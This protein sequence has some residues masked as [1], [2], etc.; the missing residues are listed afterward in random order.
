V[1]TLFAAAFAALLLAAPAAWAQNAAGANASKHGI[2]VVD[3]SYIFK[4]H[5]KFRATMDGMQ[6]EMKQIETQLEGDRKAIMGSEEQLR[7]L[8]PGAPEYST[9]DDQITQQKAQF[10]LKMT[11][12]RKDFLE[13]EAK[14]YYDTFQEVDQAIAYY[15]KNRQIGLVLRF[16]GEAPDP[17]VREDILRAINK[18]VVYQDQIDITPDVLAM[19]NARAGQQ[20]AQPAGGAAAPAS[21]ARPGSTVRQ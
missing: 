19:L 10:Q 11:R 15:A 1:R 13:R 20:A 8:K 5:A 6:G 17:N 12:L 4:N 7:A 3:I 14:V 9:L 2:G 18:P 21:A 16:N